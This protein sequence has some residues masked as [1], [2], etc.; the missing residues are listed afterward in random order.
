MLASRQ[1]ILTI[2]PRRALGSLGNHTARCPSW[3]ESQRRT[4][5]KLQPGLLWGQPSRPPAP[6]SGISSYFSQKF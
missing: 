3:A 4:H 1:T 6:T 5:G 2:A